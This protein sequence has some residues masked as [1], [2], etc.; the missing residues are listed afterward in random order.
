MI[1][2]DR[3]WEEDRQDSEVVVVFNETNRVYF[4]PHGL[5]DEEY[6]AKAKKVIDFYNTQYVKDVMRL[7]V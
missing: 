3:R 7:D 1:M 2:V 6:I 5:T 4:T